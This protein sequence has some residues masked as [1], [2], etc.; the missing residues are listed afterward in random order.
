MSARITEYGQPVPETAR[1]ALWLTAKQIGHPDVEGKHPR[2]VRSR[3]NNLVDG[4]NGTRERY[5]RPVATNGGTS[6][7]FNYALLAEDFPGTVKPEALRAAIE[8]YSARE[9]QEQLALESASAAIQPE[10][11][12]EQTTLALPFPKEITEIH[13]VPER[14]RRLVE[15]RYRAIELVNGD[16]WL[17][18]KGQSIHGIPVRVKDDFVGALARDYKLAARGQACLVDWNAIQTELAQGTR[19][20]DRDERSESAFKKRLWSWHSWYKGGKQTGAF[21]FAP[22]I[23]ALQDAPTANAGKSKLFGEAPRALDFH[24]EAEMAAE[25]ER[26]PPAGKRLFEL[27]LIEKRSVQM[28]QEILLRERAELGLPETLSHSAVNRFY[29]RIP[30]PLLLWSRGRAKDFHDQCASYALRD[31]TTCQVTQWQVL[32]HGQDDFFVHNDYIPELDR[33]AFPEL[34]S[35]EELR[36]WWT[37]VMD[38]RS[39]LIL[40]YAVCA[41]PNSDTICSAERMAILRTGRVPQFVLIDNGKDFKKTG[42]E[43]PNLPPEAQGVLLRLIKAQW[44]ESGRIILAI[45]EHAQSKAPLERWF[46]TK[47][48][49]FDKQVDSYCGRS[50]ENRPDHCTELL[51][52]HRQFLL[53]KREESPLPRASQAIKATAWWIETLYNRQH[54]HTGQGMG[55]R[56]PDEVFRRG[57]PDSERV[58]ALA[59]LDRSELDVFLRQRDPKPKKVFEGGCVK[60]FGQEFEPADEKNRGRLLA[61]VGR[62]VL[63]AADAYRVGD[64]VAFDPQTGERLGDLICKKL[65][66]WGASKADIRAKMRLQRGAAK[67]CRTY[68]KRLQSSYHVPEGAFGFLGPEALRATGTDGMRALP[69]GRPLNF[70]GAPAV[71][72]AP[73]ITS[74]FVKKHGAFGD[75]KVED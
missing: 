66:A 74:D 52:Q 1:V 37:V 31:Y 10:P 14:A 41:I 62:K 17:K 55:R 22:G 43:R 50:P 26:M 42:K 67:S 4:L 21:K 51:K 9:S 15:A 65:L 71:E 23:A 38:I 40:G 30:K 27:M 11:V 7:E 53:R 13:E 68:M 16:N 54:R 18:W 5:R 58:E 12:E 73:V 44:G 57:Y 20:R 32:D 8:K 29:K 34:D 46:G 75:V 39:R 70:A 28:T 35:N 3:L 2:G 69:P 63:V 6:Y 60:M 19:K 45:G 59:K 25:F 61:C 36:M 49:R 33:L 47:R 64:A 56:T 72:A 24:D 48:T